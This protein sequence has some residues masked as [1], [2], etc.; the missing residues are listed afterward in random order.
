MV[1]ANE[2]VTYT[3]EKT[4]IAYTVPKTIHSCSKSPSFSKITTMVVGEDATPQGADGFS[5]F[6]HTIKDNYYANP[7]TSVNYYYRKMTA[8]ESAS[9]SQSFSTS[10]S[11]SESESPTFE[12]ISRSQVRILGPSIAI[13]ESVRILG[14]SLGFCEPV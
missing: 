9:Q 1:F 5:R 10:S 11:I 2:T 3:D 4:G 7:M 8:S 14:S 12:S 13:C 6:K